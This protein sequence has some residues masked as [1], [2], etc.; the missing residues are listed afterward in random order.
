MVHYIIGNNEHVL[1]VDVKKIILE[2]KWQETLEISFDDVTSSSPHPAPDN[3]IKDYHEYLVNEFK[4]SDFSLKLL[5]YFVKI[6]SKPENFIYDRNFDCNL[7]KLNYVK[8]IEGL[9]TVINPEVQAYEIVQREIDTFWNTMRLETWH[10]LVG[11]YFSYN[12][13]IFINKHTRWNRLTVNIVNNIIH[14]MLIGDIQAER[15]DCQFD[16]IDDKVSRWLIDM[17]LPRVPVEEVKKIVL[18]KIN[19]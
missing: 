18:G 4:I 7:C 11:S 3:F 19:C 12:D 14:L 17:E 10:Y 1:H 6:A 15:L 13:T 2:E 9:C 5:N 16:Q 8:S